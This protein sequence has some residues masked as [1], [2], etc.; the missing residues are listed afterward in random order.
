MTSL[1]GV[2]LIGA[3]YAGFYW[4]V[5]YIERFGLTPATL[6]GRVACLIVTTVAAFI[7]S[8]AAVVMSQL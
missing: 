6:G 3:G 7:V 5:P 8:G 4:C 1:F 2:L